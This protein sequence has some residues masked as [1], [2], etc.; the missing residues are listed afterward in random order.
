MN[1]G[2]YVVLA[3]TKRA[4]YSS[5]RL[6]LSWHLELP[7]E[8]I[9]VQEEILVVLAE[10]VRGY[11][12]GAWRWN[13]GLVVT[14]ENDISS[15]VAIIQTWTPGQKEGEDILL[16]KPSVKFLILDPCSSILV[17][18]W[19]LTMAVVNLVGAFCLKVTLYLIIACIHGSSVF[20]KGRSML[21][22]CADQL[23][24]M[25]FWWK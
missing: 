9:L 5:V 14:L 18:V 20:V 6:K 2:D 4:F 22:T 21:C 16:L 25:Y 24:G 19:R 11:V 1:W 8:Y 15:N 10:E 17:A 12:G 23:G 7:L 3:L 13:H